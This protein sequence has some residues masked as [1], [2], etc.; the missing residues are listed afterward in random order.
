M[1]D[2]V[3]IECFGDTSVDARQP[4]L[5]AVAY[6]GNS[7]E[8][9]GIRSSYTMSS[10]IDI[11]TDCIINMPLSEIEF[12]TG[13]LSFTGTVDSTDL[14]LSSNLISGQNQISLSGTTPINSGDVLI[15]QNTD[16]YSFSFHS[17][18]C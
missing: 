12:T 5:D 4:F 11:T 3:Y 6:A 9:R 18:G 8:V 15:I 2:F 16:D 13:G 14:T 7:L 17:F 10:S 1:S